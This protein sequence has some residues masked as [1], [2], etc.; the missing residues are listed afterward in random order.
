MN[1]SIKLRISKEDKR[2]LNNE[3]K[4]HRISVSAYIRSTML[5]D[6]PIDNYR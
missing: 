5:N 6:K 3:A 1:D 4:K 2:L